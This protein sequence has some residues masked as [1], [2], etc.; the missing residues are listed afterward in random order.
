MSQY[1]AQWNDSYEEDDHFHD[2]Q[3]NSKNKKSTDDNSKFSEFK[4]SENFIVTDKFFKEIFHDYQHKIQEILHPNDLRVKYNQDNKFT[5]DNKTS[6]NYIYN[7]FADYIFS[8][9]SNNKYIKKSN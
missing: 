5:D 4:Q 8:G 2:I 9:M 7:S 6:T 1:Y 3:G